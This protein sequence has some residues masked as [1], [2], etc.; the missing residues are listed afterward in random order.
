MCWFIRGALQG[1]VDADALSAINRRHNCSILQGTKHTVKM[2][3]LS[4]SSDC[5]ITDG[6]CDCDS[7][8]GK[9]DPNAPMVRDLAALIEDVSILQGAE[10]VF[11][12][13]AWVQR[14]NKHEQ[15]LKLSDVDLERFLAD[16]EPSTLYTIYCKS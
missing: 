1:N 9:H 4:D 13:K 2:A 10:A 11:L 16:L 14:R 6:C 12:C 7:D 8:I 15:T 5:R 3:I